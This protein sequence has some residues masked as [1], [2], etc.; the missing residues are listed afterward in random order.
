MKASNLFIGVS[1]QT[2]LPPLR[3]RKTSMADPVSTASSIAGFVELA[4]V[5]LRASRELYVFFS[6]LRNSTRKIRLLST[7]LKDVSDI[8]SEVRTFAC[9]HDI[10][11]FRAR[12]RLK[13]EG[14]LD[15]LQ[16]CEKYVAKMKTKLIPMESAVGRTKVERVGELVSMGLYEG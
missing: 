11:P 6:A 15:T 12:D 9:D 5:A 13:I 2:P 1:V 14:L 3:A 4:D 10:S 7:E 16:A 8:L